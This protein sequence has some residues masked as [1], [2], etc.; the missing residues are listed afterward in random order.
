LACRRK[1]IEDDNDHGDDDDDCDAED[2]MVIIN[3]HTDY[4]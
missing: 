4:L 3:Y 1:V 2:K